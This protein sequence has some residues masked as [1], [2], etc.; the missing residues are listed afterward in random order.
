MAA[1]HLQ[2]ADN[3]FHV[4]TPLLHSTSLSRQVGCNI[5]LKCENLQP[6]G[7]VKIR[8]M[9]LAVLRAVN[10]AMPAQLVTASTGNAAV[11]LAYVSR[12]L[13][14]PANVFVPQNTPAHIVTSA[15]NEG[16]T[17]TVDGSDLEEAVHLAQTY[18]QQHPGCHFIHPFDDADVQQ[19]YAT[20]IS[21]I[22]LQLGHQPPEGILLGV[23]G[24]G[25]LAGV[26]QGLDAHQWNQVPAI[27]VETHG[28]NAFQS[29]R[30]SGQVQTLDACKTLASGLRS[31]RVTLAAINQSTSH[32][33]IPFSVSDPMAANACQLFAACGAVLSLIYSGV[34]RDVI[35]NLE[36]SSNIVVILAGGLDI[37][38]EQLN[39]FRCKYSNPPIIVKS[40]S[41][42][43]MR[44][45]SDADASKSGK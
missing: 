36:P 26:L 39:E 4:P 18:A 44:L 8:G 14:R 23:G 34:I 15:K 33:V 25:L 32:P 1:N 17:V 38:V 42:I 24:G 43:Y 28:S 45:A 35:P 19:G 12:Q 27:A 10:N 22:K 16:A 40:G 11:A 13:N 6:S 41:E 29:S 20:L 9:G 37:T 31:K 30:V 2:T 5:W 21:E 7:S 3:L